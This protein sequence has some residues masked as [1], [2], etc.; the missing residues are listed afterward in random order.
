MV[1]TG[2]G[3]GKAFIKVH[4]PTTHQYMVNINKTERGTFHCAFIPVVAGEHSI[5]V[6]W[7]VAHVP[8]SPFKLVVEKLSK[9][10]CTANGSGLKEA[11]V[12]K[13]AMFRIITNE[14][15]LIDNGML[16]VSIRT[17][18]CE[19]ETEIDDKGD[20]SY[21]VTFTVQ[22]MGAYI[23]E[24]KLRDQHI[25]GSPCKIVVAQ[26]VDASKCHVSGIKSDSYQYANV[27]Q[28]FY[29]DTSQGGSGTLKVTVGDP[30]DKQID[31]YIKRGDNDKFSVRF[32]TGSEGIYTINVLWSEVHVPGSPFKVHV[33][34]LATPNAKMVKA[35]GPGLHNGKLREWTEF[36]IVTRQAGQGTLTINGHSVNGTF[37]IP[38]QPKGPSTYIARYYPFIIGDVFIIIRWGGIQIPGS[39]FKVKIADSA[40]K[41]ETVAFI[42]PPTK[43]TTGLESHHDE[44]NS[45]KVVSSRQAQDA[46]KPMPAKTQHDEIEVDPTINIKKVCTIMATHMYDGMHNRCFVCGY[47]LLVIM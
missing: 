30:N 21:D 34:H 23:A 28:E 36:T 19:A 12:G 42:K 35:Y 27:S 15:G 37:E 16:F 47:I 40:I 38:T 4:G 2:A 10:V 8:G 24:I 41:A 29:I 43:S 26:D 22:E 32:I 14:R 25:V 39:P 13:P 44:K 17:I 7:G 3:I 20:G 6:M 31:T 9:F 33:K 5:E 45:F 11:V 18:K 1:V 46:S